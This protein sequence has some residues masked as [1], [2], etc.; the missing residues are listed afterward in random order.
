[1]PDRSLPPLI[2]DIRNIRLPKPEY[3]VL[4]NGIPAY[5][6]NLGTQEVTRLELVFFA[7]RTYEQKPL[8]A[9]ATSNL[10][11]EGTKDYSASEIAEAIDYFGAT[12]SF[13]FNLDTSSIVLYSLNKHFED[14]L[15]LLQSILASPAFTEKDLNAYVKRSQRRLAVDLAKNDILSYRLITEHIFGKNHPYGYNSSEV[16]YAALTPQD[17]REHHQRLYNASNCMVFVSG[18]VTKTAIDK[19]NKTLSVALKAGDKPQP[20]VPAPGNQPWASTEHRPDT[21]QT[22]IRIGR[23][24]N[25]RHHKDFNGLYVLN[26]LLGGYFG[27]RLM[28][29]IREEKGYTYNIS[30]MLE[31]MRFDGSLL[32]GTEVSPEYVEP[33]LKEIYEEMKLLQ[34]EQVEQ[35]ELKMVRNFLLGNFLTMLDGPFNVSEVVRAFVVDGLPLSAFDDL[36]AT[37]QNID[38]P[39]LQELAQKYLNKEDMWQV[40]VGP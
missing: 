27:S 18:K 5:I 24:F 4:D 17:L 32:I 21:L 30:S 11:R 22:S 1:M 29:N 23:R 33:T 10:L 6:S 19:L 8:V 40:I 7:G 12:L 38:A 13:P 26:T 35:E 31:T 9:R 39:A 28:T 3:L 34:E 2:E 20:S 15:P 14:T 36:V 37:V 16:S 25:N